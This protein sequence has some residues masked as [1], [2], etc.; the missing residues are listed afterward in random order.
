MKATSADR[1]T[2]ENVKLISGVTNEQ[3][4]DFFES[5]VSYIVLNYLQEKPTHLP[6]LGDITISHDADEI[7]SEG[8]LAKLSIQ[9]TPD[10]NLQKIIG[11]IADDE[12]TEI[13]KI[14]R[15]KTKSELDAEISNIM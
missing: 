3:C 8:K 1:D 4:R 2:I 9:I 11:Q 12:E 14:F 6:F 15:D 10:F 5:L 7:T 13:E